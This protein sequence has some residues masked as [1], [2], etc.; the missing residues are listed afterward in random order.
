[1]P[2]KLTSRAEVPSLL[3]G[4]AGVGAPGRGHHVDP[5]GSDLDEEQAVQR[6]KE[7]GLDREEVT[8]Q[9][10]LGLRAQELGPGGPVSSGGWPETAFVAD[11]IRGRRQRP[12]PSPGGTTPSGAYMLRLD[13]SA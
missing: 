13:F 12:R 5:T 10:P 11:E 3:G 1:V 6:L 2:F 8:G 4:V 9:D 7:G